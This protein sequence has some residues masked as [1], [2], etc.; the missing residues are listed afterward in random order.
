MLHYSYFIYSSALAALLAIVIFLRRDLFKD[1]I[2]SFVFGAVLG[3]VVEI[4]YG[5]DYWHPPSI[6]HVDGVR[7]E[8]VLFGIAILGLA[9]VLYP[10][11]FRKIL[12]P[13]ASGRERHLKTFGTLA[14]IALCLVIFTKVLQINSV[15]ATAITFTA[16]WLLIC[17]RRKDLLLPGF[18]SGLL[19]VCLAF[20]I[21]GVFLNIFISE[22]DLQAIWL[23]H[24]SRLGITILGKVPVSELVWFFGV[25]CLLSIF[26]LFVNNR[27]YIDK[28]LPKSK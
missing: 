23:I 24:N 14:A 18:T 16:I 26:E 21:Y 6:W 10:F 13:I 4:L 5:S 22:K 1:A 15:Y 17:S 2:P 11:I 8:D 25:G 12:S 20:I 19:F 27:T 28:K 7:I 9:L 3:P